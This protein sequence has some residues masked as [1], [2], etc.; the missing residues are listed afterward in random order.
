L[1]LVNLHGDVVATIPIE[2]DVTQAKRSAFSATDE[3]GIPI[4]NT[5]TLKPYQ[6]VGAAM[7]NDDTLGGLIQM[8]A[9]NYNPSTGRFLSMDPVPGGNPNAFT[10]PVDPVNGYDLDGNM[11]FVGPIYIPRSMF[12]A[13]RAAC[14][15]RVGRRS[16][17]DQIFGQAMR[18]WKSETRAATATTTSKS[19]VAKS[20]G[21]RYGTLLAGLTNV[22]WG[23][24]NVY[25]A[26]ATIELLP[27]ASAGGP[28]ATAGTV[29]LAGYFLVSAGVKVVGGVQ[30][31][32]Q[33]LEPCGSRCRVNDQMYDYVV[34]VAP[35]GEF[36][37][38]R[39]G[40][41]QGVRSA[42]PW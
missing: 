4:V 34:G 41:L 33:G 29:G 14:Y 15:Y 10:Y 23:V 21:I 2:S 32:G 27:I 5:P 19:A 3:Y 35:L 13:F 6:W 20:S 38:G 1:N 16:E 22:A 39:P 36:Y 31:I 26:R 11:G 24:A 12:T 9:R 30:Q 7:R 18:Q 42:F 25:K 8:G 28:V 37:N 40:F 17:G